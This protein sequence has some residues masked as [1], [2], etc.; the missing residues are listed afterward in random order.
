MVCE[1]MTS[2]SIFSTFILKT[3][4]SRGFRYPKLI[5]FLKSLYQAVHLLVVH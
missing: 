1:Y 5:F 4:F 3:Q 2:F